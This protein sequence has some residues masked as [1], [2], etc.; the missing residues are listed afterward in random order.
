M[1]SSGLLVS[2]D[3]NS[4]GSLKKYYFIRAAY[5]IVDESQCFIKTVKIFL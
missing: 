3:E 2:A 1:L 5:F 4:I